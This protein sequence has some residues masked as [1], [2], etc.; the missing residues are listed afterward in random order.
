MRANLLTTSWIMLRTGLHTAFTSLLTCYKAITGKI[1][2]EWCDKTM[3]RWAK[4][5]LSFVRVKM[6]VFNPHHI[7][8]NAFDRTI[9]M[10]NHSSHYDIPITIEALPYSI[11]MLAKK[12]LSKIP[13][14]GRMLK[15]AEF[16]FIDRKNRE[17]AIIDLR[18]AQE[19]MESGLIIWIAPEGTRSKDGKVGPLKKGGF[20]MAI[21]SNATI[22]PVGIR[23]ARKILPTKTWHFQT[24]CDV[25]VHIGEPI[26]ASAYGRENKD[27]LIKN[28]REALITLS[29]EDK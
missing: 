10:V 19:K 13:L 26:E 28:V 20:I 24:D 7:D 14:F 11:R 4:R 25:E 15:L 1:N 27:A 2:R 17:Q 12:E 29:G 21:D 16:P 5:T 8:V 6:Q 9:V 22:I 3:H 18:K 23:G